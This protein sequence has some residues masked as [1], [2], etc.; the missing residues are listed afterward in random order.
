M[1]GCAKVR[2]SCLP[3]VDYGQIM[4]RNIESSIDSLRAMAWAYAAFHFYNTTPSRFSDILS[5]ASA[6][7][8]AANSKIMYQYARGQRVPSRGK[9]GKNRFDLISAVE[10]FDPV[11]GKLVTGWLT[12]PLWKIFSAKIELGD[13]QSLPVEEPPGLQYS[14][15]YFLVDKDE[16]DA[17]CNDERAP[18]L[19]I[20]EDF[21]YVCRIFVLHYKPGIWAP[22]RWLLLRLIEQAAE[23]DEVFWYIRKPFRKMIDDFYPEIDFHEDKVENQRGLVSSIGLKPVSQT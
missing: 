7:E 5:Q 21:V 12:H 10:E 13:M 2:Q 22:Y 16:I 11:T 20:F 15:R 9:R 23:V 4:H 8:S 17:I 14:L 18:R 1:D 6:G 3:P 19:D